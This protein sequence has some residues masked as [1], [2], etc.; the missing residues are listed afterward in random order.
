[1]R[2]TDPSHAPNEQLDRLAAEREAVERDVL[3]RVKRPV[4]WVFRRVLAST[5]LHMVSRERTKTNCVKLVQEGR[6][7]A[8]ELGRRRVAGRQLDQGDGDAGVQVSRVRHDGSGLAQPREL[9]DGVVR[10]EL[11]GLLGDPTLEVV[12]VRMTVPVRRDLR[13]AHAVDDQ[14]HQVGLAGGQPLLGDGALTFWAVPIAAG[15]VRD[16]AVAAA[17]AALDVSAERGGAAVLDGR[18]DLELAETEVSG[19]CVTPRRPVGAEDI[20]DLQGRHARGLDGR[21]DLQVLQW[22]FHLA[23]EFGRHLAIT[24]GVLNFLVPQKHLDDANILVVL[25]QVRGEGMT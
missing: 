17:L 19:L 6:M 1:M 21:L 24:G 22:S 10:T 16:P 3:N 4:R 23:Q 2:F 12:L 8:H 7:G 13:H 9:D 15:V 11:A 20:R 18:H 5:R 25:E 14:Q